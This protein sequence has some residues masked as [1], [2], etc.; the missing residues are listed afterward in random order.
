[1]WI[2]ITKQLKVENYVAIIHELK[3]DNN[4]EVIAESQ[5]R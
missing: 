2:I 5:S 1:M 4:E 3:E